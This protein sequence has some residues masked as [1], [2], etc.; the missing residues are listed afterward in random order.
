MVDEMPRLV[1]A[2]ISGSHM[3]GFPSVDSDFDIR[4]MHVEPPRVM[5]GLDKPV[6]TRELLDGDF[7]FV[8]QEARKFLLLLFKN[9][10][11]LEQ[12]WSPL[13]IYSTPE[14]EKL[15]QLSLSCITHS[16]AAHYF[17]FADAQRHM[18]E[19]RKVYEVKPILYTYRIYMAGIH[20]LRERDVVSDINVLNQEHNLGAVEDLIA[21]KI[22]GEHVVARESQMERFRSDIDTLRA[23]LLEAE[24]SNPLPAYIEQRVKDQVN[25]LLIEMREMSGQ[26]D[27]DAPRHAHEKDLSKTGP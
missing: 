15:K 22:K 25:D 27:R 23:K 13:V 3:F 1:F 17:G 4:G 12:L 14:H 10:N 5:L 21:Q 26:A 16:H 6:E 20:L 19:Q 9:G 8:S 11:A 7:D 24:E 2:A 18:F